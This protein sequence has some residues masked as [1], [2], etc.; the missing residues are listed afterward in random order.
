MR[1]PLRTR[2]RREGVDAAEG[3]S[4]EEAVGSGGDLDSVS[5]HSPTVMIMSSNLFF[6]FRA[7]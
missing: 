6:F 4:K 5:R 3:G 2:L 1:V 7:D